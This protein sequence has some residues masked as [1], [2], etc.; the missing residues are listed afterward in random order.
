MKALPATEGFRKVSKGRKRLNRPCPACGNLSPERLQLWCAIPEFEV[1]RCRDCEATFINAVI[2]DNT[3]FDAGYDIKAAPVLAAKGREDFGRLDSI[4]KTF[5]IDLRA[6]RRLLDIGCGIGNFLN[7]ARHAGWEVVGLDLS[8]SVAA[9][10]RENRELNVNVGS[11]ESSTGFSSESFDVIT[12]F[13]VIEHLA[14]P[15]GAVR[16]CLRLLRR[17]GML[18]LQ[19]PNEDGLMRRVGRFLFWISSGVVNF[20]V[21]ELYQ[22]GGGHS[23]CFTRRSIRGLLERGG[24]RVLNLE[25][26]TYGLR[27]LVMRFDGLPLVSRLVHSS[28]TIA[29]FMLGSLIGGSNHVTVYAQKPEE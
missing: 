21:K 23:V 1:V 5:Q 27:V 22:M 4:L 25:D 19:T 20:H 6:D 8:P 13:G 7:H 9:Y 15:V 14:D 17:G 10:A 24:F 29:L 11:I 18:V 12:M 16:E 3:G 2:D 26:S 28:G